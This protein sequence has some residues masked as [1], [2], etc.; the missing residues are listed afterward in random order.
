MMANDRKQ[1]QPSRGPKMASDLRKETPALV[2]A[3][4]AVASRPVRRILSGRVAYLPKRSV[5]CENTA[6]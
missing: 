6:L 2:S 3:G 1:P 4:V 5:T